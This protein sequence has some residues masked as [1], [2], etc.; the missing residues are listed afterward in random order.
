MP[1]SDPIDDASGCLFRGS[2][3]RAQRESTGTALQRFRQQ[4]RVRA[5]EAFA[6]LIKRVALTVLSA[7]E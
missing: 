2:D 7:Y 6:P 5:D 1:V 3:R 4:I